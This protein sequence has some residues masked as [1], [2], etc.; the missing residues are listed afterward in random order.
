M[1]EPTTGTPTA[2]PAVTQLGVWWQSLNDATKLI[3]N[4]LYREVPE[5]VLRVLTQ[6]Q[7]QPDPAHTSI[8]DIVADVDPGAAFSL[9]GVDVYEVTVEPANPKR[10]EAFTVT[11]TRSTKGAIPEHTDAVQILDAEAKVVAERSLASAATT[12]DARNELSQGF[13][14][15]SS[16]VY[17]LVVWAN[18]EGGDGTGVPTAQGTRGTGSTTLYVGDTRESQVAQQGPHAGDAMGAVSGAAFA[19]NE[20]KQDFTDEQLTIWVD[21]FEKRMHEA[22]AALLRIDS[23][24]DGFQSELHRVDG[25]LGRWS[26]IRTMKDEGTLPG[27]AQRLNG[28][29][30][31]DAITSPGDLGV[32]VIDVIDEVYGYDE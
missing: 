28:M 18:L 10:D 14:G 16:G 2:S 8:D 26:K 7:L 19:I 25:M 5:P 27:L 4:Q 11:W 6:G 12:G 9:P 29:A 1:P 32:A 31:M 23:L 21:E 22:I 17:T 15:L 30:A 13:D 24:G 20:I 3:F